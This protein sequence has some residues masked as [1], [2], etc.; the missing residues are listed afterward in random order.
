M[1]PYRRTS[2]LPSAKGAADFLYSHEKMAAIASA[3]SRLAALRKDCSAILPAAFEHCDVLQYDSGQ[4]LLAAPNAAFASR[5]K[6][7]LPQLRNTLLQRGW[8]IDTIRIKV[9]LTQDARIAPR[10]K[11]LALPSQAIA[12]FAQLSRSLPRSSANSSLQEAVDRLIE[13]HRQPSR[14]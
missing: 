3:V 5:I 8:K 11:Q 13:H 12:A 7:Q 1:S 9:Q 14:K 2:P 10:P 4:L 6:Q